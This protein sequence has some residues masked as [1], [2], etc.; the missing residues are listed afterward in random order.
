MTCPI[1]REDISSILTFLNLP[2]SE[3]GTLPLPPLQF[4]QT[5]L[6]QLPPSLL[7]HF[8]F[9]SPKERTRIK[10]I[11]RR[12]LLQSTT[13]PR[14]L[15]AGEGRLRWPLLWERLG[16]DPYLAT[17]FSAED[18]A[19]WAN[20]SFMSG[21]PDD[22]QVRKLGGFLRLMEE[23]REA[24]DVR[25]AKR[26]ERALETVGEEFEEESDDEDEEQ[27]EQ[28]RPVI[29]DDQER[30]EII[31]EKQLLELFLDGLDTIDYSPIDFVDPAEGDPI[32][33]RDAQDKYFDE[34]EPSRTPGGT[35]Q[36]QEGVECDGS[37]VREDDDIILQNGQG[38]YDY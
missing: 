27:T 34:E 14:F 18:E 13:K 12:R 31:F 32:A 29:A 26:M 24:E 7:Q 20:L 37:C 21:T 8:V 9:I 23:E 38:N 15:T 17:S 35:I 22:Q 33:L 28:Q 10:Q 2:S 6:S 30:V 3:S 1:A 25:A 11:K 16:G 36:G 5:Y 4:L 19:A